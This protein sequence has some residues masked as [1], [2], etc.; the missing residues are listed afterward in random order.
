LKLFASSFT[1]DSLVGCEECRSVEDTEDCAIDSGRG[2]RCGVCPD[3]EPLPPTPPG[4]VSWDTGVEEPVAG[5]VI[6][7]DKAFCCRKRSRADASATRLMALT[8]LSLTPF[9]LAFFSTWRS[10]SGR[11]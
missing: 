10:S 9:S 11:N 5:R 7:L 6:D 3:R 8:W 1:I 4:A 2:E